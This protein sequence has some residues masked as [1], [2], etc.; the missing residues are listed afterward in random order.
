M[1]TD[2]NSSAKYYQKTIRGYKKRLTKDIKIFL[3]NKKKKMWQ[4]DHERYKNLPEHENVKMKNM[5]V[6]LLFKELF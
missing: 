3:K 1:K 5:N 2:K 4:L 6:S